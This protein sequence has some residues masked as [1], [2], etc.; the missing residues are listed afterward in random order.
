MRA[1]L[2]WIVTL[3]LALTSCATKKVI[4]NNGIE[5]YEAHWAKAKEDIARRATFEFSCPEPR[6]DFTLLHREGRSPT[7]VVVKGCGRR[8]LYERPVVRLGGFGGVYGSAYSGVGEWRLV[9]TGIDDP[10]APPLEGQ[11]KEQEQAPAPPGAVDAGR[12]SAQP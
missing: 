5:V 1:H 8:A 9:S 7:E 2:L 11:R 10:A 6:L 12:D 4:I 3:G